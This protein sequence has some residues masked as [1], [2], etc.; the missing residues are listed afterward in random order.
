MLFFILLKY[1][2]F[3]IV[4]KVSLDNKRDMVLRA[5]THY[6]IIMLVYIYNVFTQILMKTLILCQNMNVIN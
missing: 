2:K 3:Y 6:E 4:E 5:A 1:G